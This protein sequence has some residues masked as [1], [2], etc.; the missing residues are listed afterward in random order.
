MQGENEFRVRMV[1]RYVVT[2]FTSDGC[3]NGNCRQLGEY[4]NIEQADEVG[5]A[6]AASVPGAVF[7][8]VSDRREPVAERYAYTPEQADRLMGDPIDTQVG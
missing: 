1:K 2:H 8:T 5:R 4:P 7:A 3:G 6:L